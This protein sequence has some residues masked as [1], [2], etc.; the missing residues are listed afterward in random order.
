VV[1]VEAVAEPAAHRGLAAREHH[2]HQRRQHQQQRERLPHRR[3][4]ELVEGRVQRRG[5]Q[6]RHGD[7]PRG[8]AAVPVHQRQQ[9]DREDRLHAAVQQRG[10]ET[11]HDPHRDVRIGELLQ[12]PEVLDQREAGADGEAE[13]RGVD[14]EADAVRAHQRHHHA[15]LE[16]LLDERGQRARVRAELQAGEREQAA[17]RPVRR[18]RG[19]GPGGY[20]Q[21]DQAQAHELVAVHQHQ[22][23]QEPGHRQQA[24]A[25]A[26]QHA[27]A[28]STFNDTSHSSSS[29]WPSSNPWA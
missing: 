4:D 16:Q 3:Q 20:H 2:H 7:G 12:V 24:E 10:A 19:R 15:R 17:V 13:D 28:H 23:D 29:F 27:A 14:Q 11:A 21:G 22:R 18:Q 8:Q 26:Q 1:G 6:Q 9:P 25:R 5:G